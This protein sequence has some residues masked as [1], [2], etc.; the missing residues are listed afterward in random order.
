[1]SVMCQVMSRVFCR[2]EKSL[3]CVQQY[4]GCFGEGKIVWAMWNVVQGVLEKG[5]ES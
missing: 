5:G 1:M 2:R 3:G 4:P